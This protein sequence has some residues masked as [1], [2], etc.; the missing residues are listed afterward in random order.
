MHHDII[1]GGPMK[2]LEPWL[3]GCENQTTLLNYNDIMA[4]ALASDEMIEKYVQI[5]LTQ[6]LNRKR[7]CEAA[8]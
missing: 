1:N 7:S 3:F 5:A 4:N 2:Y 8:A 6:S